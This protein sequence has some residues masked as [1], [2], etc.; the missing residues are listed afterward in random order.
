MKTSAPNTLLA[1]VALAGALF[2]AAPAAQAQG[3]LA[4]VN[5]RAITSLDVSQRVRIAAMTERRRLG[6]REALE[7]LI[8]DQ[9]KVIEAGRVGYRVTEE[10]VEAEFAK[11]A[12]ANNQSAK[13]FE[14]TLRG[15][16]LEPNALRDKMRANI[17]WQAL[18]RDRVKF[19]TQVTRSEV[20]SAATEKKRGNDKKTEYSLI[21]VVF[22]VP[23]GS[24]P[25]ARISA[26][27]AARAKFSNCDTD[28][29][30]LRAMP[31]VFVRTMTVRSSDDISK[32]L[33]ATL[34]KT[35]VGRMTAPAAGEQGIELVAVCNKRDT[36]SNAADLAVVAEELGEKK[37][38]AGS[39]AYL[40]ELR[41]KVTIKYH[42]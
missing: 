36:S 39:K 32:E 9:A 4:Q 10:G 28:F 23:P 37:V 41:K 8:D 6:A 30:A 14:Q 24:S 21:P 13:Q 42:R 1:A 29:D 40:A 27:N 3:I 7:E 31:D 18:L 15:A 20:E 26:A 11:L 12:K 34:D 2:I 38:N 22:I 5:H 33:R 35:P 16:G 25:A 19:G 17:A